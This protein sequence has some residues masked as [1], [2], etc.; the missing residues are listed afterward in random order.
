MSR[1]KN[2]SIELTDRE[3]QTIFS[4]ARNGLVVHRVAK[5]LFY[6]DNGIK[7]LIGRIRL[8][9]RLN[10]LDFYDMIKLIALI[11]GDL[12]GNN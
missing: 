3:K 12:N 7:Y 10:P 9:T 2:E 11:G 1:P 6:T 5:E 4:L 8:K